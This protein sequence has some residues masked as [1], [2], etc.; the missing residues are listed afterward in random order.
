MTAAP[1]FV[2]DKFW[3]TT[4]NLSQNSALP[5][6]CLIKP[7][8]MKDPETSIAPLGVDMMDPKTPTIRL[9]S[10]LLFDSFLEN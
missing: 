6:I 7:S 2:T 8:K 3:R 9:R 1:V 5:D 4:E 10:A